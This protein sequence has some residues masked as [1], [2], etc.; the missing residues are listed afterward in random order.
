MSKIGKIIEHPIGTTRQ[1]LTD[2]IL[3]I[4][5]KKQFINLMKTLVGYYA[6]SYTRCVD[7]VSF[8]P[9]LI[10]LFYKDGTDKL[11]VKYTLE[12]AVDVKNHIEIVTEDVGPFQLIK[13]VK[14]LDNAAST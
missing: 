5:D 10:I 11:F 9:Q 8:Q 2:T 13:E 14:E 3:I 4:K 7:P 6:I 1:E 12:L